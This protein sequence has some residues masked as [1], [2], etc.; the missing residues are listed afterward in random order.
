MEN[1]LKFVI[2][3][4][5]EELTALQQDVPICKTSPIARLATSAAPPILTGA[6]QEIHGDLN[7]T[8]ISI[9]TAAVEAAILLYCSFACRY[10][11]IK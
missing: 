5:G 7:T 10:R 8:L 4:I 6:P 2:T 9:L 1:I 3:L 11:N